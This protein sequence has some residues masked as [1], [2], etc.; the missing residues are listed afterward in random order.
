MCGP[1]R[2]LQTVLC[3]Y[4]FCVSAFQSRCLQTALRGHSL[5]STSSRSGL[6]THSSK[7]LNSVVWC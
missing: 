5:P 2:C 6:R 4:S 7:H 1:T 3:A